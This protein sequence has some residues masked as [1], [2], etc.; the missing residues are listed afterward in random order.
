[1]IAAARLLAADFPDVKF[2]IVGGGPRR[3]ELEALV[4]THRLEDRVLFLGHREDVGALLGGSDVFVL[5]S[6]SEAFPNGAIKP[7]RPGC[8]WSPAGSE[9]C[10]T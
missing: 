3:A 6:R 1:M 4:R 2:H 9:A 8:R 5:P 7:W 10:S